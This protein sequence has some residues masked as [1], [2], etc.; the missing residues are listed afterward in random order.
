MTR[1][2]ADSCSAGRQAWTDRMQPRRLVPSTV[3][4]SS[5]VMSASRLSGKMPALAHST[6]MPPSRSAAVAAI[7]WQSARTLTSAS[8]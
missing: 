4:R 6:S 7:R 5:S 8:T 3:S 1:P 2:C